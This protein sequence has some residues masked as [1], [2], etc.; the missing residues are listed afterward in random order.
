MV[1][2]GT[3][4]IHSR[5]IASVLSHTFPKRLAIPRFSSRYS[6][7]VVENVDYVAHHRHHHHLV[8]ENDEH[9]LDG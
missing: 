3:F 1:D 8:H 4:I 6:F 9:I 2:G 5:T 7:S